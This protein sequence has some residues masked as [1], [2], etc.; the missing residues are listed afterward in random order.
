MKQGFSKVFTDAKNV[1]EVLA[2]TSV[3]FYQILRHKILE[4]RHLRKYICFNYFSEC[5]K[6]C[7][8]KYVKIFH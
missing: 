1:S 3:N 7:I 5:G 6:L 2:E 4:D 8:D